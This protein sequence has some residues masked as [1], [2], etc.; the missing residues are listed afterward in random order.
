MDDKN[1]LISEVLYLIFNRQKRFGTHYRYFNLQN[2]LSLC[3]KLIALLY[4]DKLSNDDLSVIRISMKCI[5]KN[6]SESY[7]LN[8]ES[9]LIFGSIV[10]TEVADK[11]RE[12]AQR[13]LNESKQLFHRRRVS[14]YLHALHNLPRAYLSPNKSLI[15]GFKN[16]AISHSEAITYADRKSTRLNSSHRL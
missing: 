11:M 6:I 14:I 12:L 16:F 15:I 10:S 7:F 13:A 9:Y 3:L 4:K 8:S 1:V 2:D 5:N